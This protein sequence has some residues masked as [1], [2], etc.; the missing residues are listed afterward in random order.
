MFKRFHD[1]D[2][3]EK[4]WYI[5][6]TSPEKCAWDYITSKCDNVGVWTPNFKLA[7][8]VIG[9]SIDWISFAKKCNGNIEI[10]DNGKWWLV[11]FCRFQYPELSENTTSRPLMSYIASLKKQGLWIRY[12]NPLHNVQ[13]KDKD[14]DSYIN[15]NLNSKIKSKKEENIL[16][17]ELSNV[18]FTE[19]EYAK[20]KASYLDVYINDYVSRLSLWKPNAPRKV[21]SDLAT[22]LSWMRRDNVPKIKPKQLCPYCGKPMTDGDCLNK[23]CPRL[24]QDATCDSI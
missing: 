6:L 3:W 2:K 22:I 21:K 17:G 15:T 11:D 9:E 5:F 13:D 14:K 24:T 19:S 4:E 18:S 1:A 20:L 16:L 12:V 23:D 8:Y 10:L 7:E